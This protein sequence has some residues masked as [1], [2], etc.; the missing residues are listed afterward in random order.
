M[1]LIRHQPSFTNLCFTWR[2][3]AFVRQ[4]VGSPLYLDS[5]NLIFYQ[6]YFTSHISPLEKSEEE[7]KIGTFF[8][9]S[10]TTVYHPSNVLRFITEERVNQRLKRIIMEVQRN[11]GDM[12]RLQKPVIHNNQRRCQKT[13]HQ[14]RKH[15]DIAYK[16][17]PNTESYLLNTTR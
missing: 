1:T 16:V 7:T 15:N 14:H 4:L 9:P 17:Y 2:V 5:M 11:P 6:N 3:K 8:A 12:W 10:Q 13:D